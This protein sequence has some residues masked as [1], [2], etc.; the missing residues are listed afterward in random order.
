MDINYLLN[1]IPQGHSWTHYRSESLDAG[2]STEV[3]GDR[4][5]AGLSPELR[6][7]RSMS[8]G[9][10]RRVRSSATPP[11]TVRRSTN[12]SNLCPF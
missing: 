3:K 8:T 4:S 10:K 6:S 2:L 11:E 1:L 9:G 7:D 5:M 12:T